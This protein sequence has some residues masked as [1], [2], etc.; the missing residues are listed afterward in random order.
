MTSLEIAKKAATALDGKKGKEIKIIKIDDLTVIADYFVIA[1]GTSA[2][3]VKA[4]A[5]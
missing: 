5:N 2:T 1:T 4:L 3:Q